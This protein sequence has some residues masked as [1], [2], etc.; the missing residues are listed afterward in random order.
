MVNVGLKTVTVGMNEM[1]DV[2]LKIVRKG[3]NGKRL[4]EDKGGGKMLGF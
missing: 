4:I 1:V 2:G 3:W